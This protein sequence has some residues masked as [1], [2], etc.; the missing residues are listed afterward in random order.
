MRWFKLTVS[1]LLIIGVFSNVW[2]I[3]PLKVKINSGVDEPI[4]INNPLGNS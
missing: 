2:A 1:F 4:K 3:Q